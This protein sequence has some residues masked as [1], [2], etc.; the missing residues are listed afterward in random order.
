MHPVRPARPT[1]VGTRLHSAVPRL[2][3][4]VLLTSLQVDMCTLPGRDQRL[5]CGNQNKATY[6]P[7]T[8][9]GAGSK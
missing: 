9:R 6:R 7:V 8:L 3:H 4:D 2:G 1:H 5:S